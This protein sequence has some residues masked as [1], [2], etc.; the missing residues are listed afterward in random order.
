MAL[1]AADVMQYGSPT[2]AGKALT[3]R[4]TPSEFLVALAGRLQHSQLACIMATFADAAAAHAHEPVQACYQ[5]FCS[6]IACCIRDGFDRF[7][8]NKEGF[9]KRGYD[10]YGYNQAGYDKEGY[11]A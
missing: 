5:S 9:D 7:G 3:K 4:A 1:T 10:K 11:G 6:V 2:R 8:F